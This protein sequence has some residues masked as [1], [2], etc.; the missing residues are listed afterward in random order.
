MSGPSIVVMG[1]AGCGKSTI[2][3]ALAESLGVEFIDGD[4]LH[5]AANV[6]KMAA[7][8]PL[9]DVDRWPWL[10]AV[11]ARLRSG[12]VVV[13][14]SA[15]RHSYRDL[16]RGADGVRFVHLV[17]DPATARRRISARSM[18]FMGSSMVDSQFATLESPTADERDVVEVDAALDVDDV[19]A[20]ALAHLSSPVER[21]APLLALGGREVV[22]DDHDIRVT[23]EGL[24]D[25]LIADGCRRVLLVPPDH[26]RL[27]SRAGVMSVALRQRLLQSG[28]DVDVLPALGTHVPMGVDECRSMFGD[29]LTSEDLHVHDWRHGLE[30]L[31]EISGEEVAVITGGRFAQAVPVAVDHRLFDGYDIVVS[32]G[33]VVPHEV[34]G[35]ANFTKNLVIGL[36]GLATIHR[37]HVIGAV[38]GMESI[39]GRSVSTVRDVVDAAFDRFLAP[40]LRVVWVLS[41]V[42]DA[43]GGSIVRGLFVGEGTTQQTGGAAFR[44]AARLSQEVNIDLLDQPL[45]HVSCWLDPME[46][47]STWLG[48]KALYRTRMA[49]A[50]EGVLHVLAPGV[51]RFGEDADI[52]ALIR[53]HGYRGTEST[54]A[55]V[56]ADPDLSAN[57][58][59]A[60]HLVHGSSEGRFRVVWCTDPENGGLTRQEVESVGY[61]WESLPVAMRRLGV[62]GDTPTGTRSTPAGQPLFHIA[63]PALGLWSTSERFGASSFSASSVA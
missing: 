61:E 15:L 32:L 57:L 35:I 34:I 38:T 2:G 36:G 16:L 7:G 28:C 40:R 55:A 54:L 26:T 11:R 62:D 31:G 5:P 43:L 18:H 14:C 24:A 21:T 13:A 47:H 19:L 27:H 37:S 39:M 56:A 8:M 33:Q 60:A 10:A 50:D 12:S 4:S 45:T 1:V 29:R 51:R 53:R 6:S 46:F 42:E 44:S 52:D 22:I 58:G 49:L 30:Q 9:D 23:I 41:V 17:I 20:A 59:A 25:R 63:N 3:A 48:N